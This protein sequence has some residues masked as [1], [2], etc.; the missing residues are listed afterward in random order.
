[1]SKSDNHSHYGRGR[2]TAPRLVIAS[3]VD[4]LGRAFTVDDLIAEVRADAPGVGAATV[5]RAV[6]AMEAAHAVERVGTRDGSA[7]YVRCTA[8][9]HHHHL[10]CTGCGRVAHASC[11]LESIGAHRADDGF[12]VTGHEL[13]LYGLC[14]GCATEIPTT[15][16]RP[17]S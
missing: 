10:V 6:A 15:S 9:G 14:A 17:R 1:M 12:V 4:R 13:T 16:E 7:L 8:D 3:A 11:P 5:Y 2:V